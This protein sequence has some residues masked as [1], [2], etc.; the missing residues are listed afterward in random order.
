VD[1]GRKTVAT[2]D[3]KRCPF[4]GKSIKSAAI[5]CRYCGEFLDEDPESANRPRA[6]TGADAAVRW[7]IPID[8]SGYAIAAGYCGLLACFPLVGLL[9]GIAG[10]VTGIL[11][12]RAVR[13]NPRQ[14]GRGRAV[15]GIVMG[16]IAGVVN[17]AGVIALIYGAATRWK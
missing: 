14:S 16:S 6:E 4:C 13:R 2:A 10:V 7:L 17:L 9:F 8:R 1:V 12:L 15:F 5:K 3:T 11:A